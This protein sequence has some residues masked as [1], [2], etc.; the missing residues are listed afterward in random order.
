MKYPQNLHP[1]ISVSPGS[2]FAGNKYI[3]L[4]EVQ[5]MLCAKC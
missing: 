2:A 1:V 4:T 3:P 5:A